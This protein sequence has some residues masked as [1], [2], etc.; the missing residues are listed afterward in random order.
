MTQTTCPHGNHIG[1]LVPHPEL[2]RVCSV[3]GGPRLPPE[4]EQDAGAIERL[5]AARAAHVRRTA[6]RFGAGC[7]AGVATVFAGLGLALLRIDSGWATAVAFAFLGLAAPFALA[8]VAGIAQSLSAGKRV[9]DS[10]AAAWRNANSP[11]SDTAP[12][13]E[14][15]GPT[16]PTSASF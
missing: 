15:R 3:C 1:D 7:S 9:R 4:A 6:W 2:V 13:S 5:R 11:P 16:G 10:L 14:P 12:R 8:L